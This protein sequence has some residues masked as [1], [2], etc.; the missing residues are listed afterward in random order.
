MITKAD[1]CELANP[2][3]VILEPWG[4][5]DRITIHDLNTGE[6]V[7]ARVNMNTWDWMPLELVNQ[8]ILCPLKEALRCKISDGQQRIEK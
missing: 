3:H 7:S 5:D 8:R 2:Y 4:Y 1:L 6:H